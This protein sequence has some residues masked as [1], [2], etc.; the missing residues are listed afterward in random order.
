[1]LTTLEVDPEVASR[2]RAL[3]RQRGVPVAVY[4]RDLIEH[5]A[6]RLETGEELSPEERVLRLRRWAASHSPNTPLLSSDAINRGTIY[7]EDR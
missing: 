3:A 7:C 4:L 1:M 5:K 2:I 6:S